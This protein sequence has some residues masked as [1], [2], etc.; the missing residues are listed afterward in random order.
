MEEAMLR[1]YPDILMDGEYLRRRP[2]GMA[3]EKAIGYEVI[4]RAAGFRNIE[5]S[6]ETA[7]FV[8]TD[9][10]EWWLQMGSVGWETL[11]EKIKDDKLKRIKEDIFRDLQSYKQPDGIHFTKS[12]FF[13]SGIK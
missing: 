7:E 10:E 12:V 9:E 6:R 13:V 2:I 8:S 4:F 5:V 3:Y 11:F 1:Y